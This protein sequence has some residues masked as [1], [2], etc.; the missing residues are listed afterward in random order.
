MKPFIAEFTVSVVLGY[1]TTSC[2]SWIHNLVELKNV[3]TSHSTESVLQSSVVVAEEGGT[4]VVL[5][6]TLSVFWTAAA[7]VFSMGE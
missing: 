3:C 1:S 5:A 7:Q 2:L 6:L 4:I